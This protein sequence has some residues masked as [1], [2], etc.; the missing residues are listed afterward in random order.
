M[1]FYSSETDF[2]KDEREVDSAVRAACQQRNSIW[3]LVLS[4]L[5]DRLEVSFAPLWVMDNYFYS[6]TDPS[7]HYNGNVG[8]EVIW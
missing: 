7:I 5:L 4:T 2:P 3:G 8:I 6:S 1:G